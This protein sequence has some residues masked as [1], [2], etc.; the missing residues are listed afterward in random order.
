MP[1]E[2]LISAVDLNATTK[3]TPKM[4]K[5]TPCVWGTQ[6]GPPKYII[7]HIT[8]AS[9]AQVKH[10][11]Q[12][13]RTKFIYTILQ[14]NVAGY[15]IRVEMDP[16]VVSASGMNKNIRSDIKTYLVDE[17]DAVIVSY[18]D[19]E[20]V[21]DIPKVDGVLDLSKVKAGIVDRFQD[22]VAKRI[23]YFTESD[24]DW[25]IAQGGYVEMTRQEVLARVRSKLED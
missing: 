21:V 2:I 5:D 24:V 23:Y 19:Y 4:A 1:C 6:E 9:K 8:D 17:W 16:S 15:R 11:F 22:R 13:W 3:G 25:V 10:F 14:E 7:L 18:E 12:T 20:A